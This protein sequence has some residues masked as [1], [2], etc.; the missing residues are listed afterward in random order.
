MSKIRF[1]D[2]AKTANVSPAT[3]SRVIRNSGYVSQ[4]KR[5]AVS[6]AMLS[7]G[8]VPP[9]VVMPDVPAESKVIGL[10]TQDASVNMLFSRLADSVNHV[11]LAN[12]Y[13]VIV[14]NVAQNVSSMQITSYINMLRNLNVSGIIFNAL[15]DQLDVP[16]IRKYIT[17][18]PVPIVMIERTADIFGIN[19]VLINARE[20]MFLA[21][22]HLAQ[23]GHKKIVF[24][25]R[26]LPGHE[27]EMSRLSGFNYACEALGCKDTSAIIPTDDYTMATGYESIGAYI[28]EH[29][30]PTAIIGSDELLVGVRRCL[31][32]RSIRVPEDVSL[33]GLD[34]T[35]SRYNIPALTSLTFPE[36]EIAENAVDI[37]IKV[38]TKKAR[39][40]TILLSP[41]LVERGSVANVVD[42]V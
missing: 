15:G 4:D 34:D 9:E 41:S 37:I 30:C 11:A 12:N 21:V 27:V 22:H 35:L 7:L 20:G 36:L 33:I 40:K 1:Q 13:N 26:D 39:P 8:Y 14:I 42:I 24:I 19:K 38:A 28:N 23:H 5:D 31:H 25:N 6:Q 29:D 32:E 17:N 3:V 2:I 10:L 16:A 18:L